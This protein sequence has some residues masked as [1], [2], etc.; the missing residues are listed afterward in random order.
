MPNLAFHLEVLDKVIDKLTTGGDP[1]GS[2]MKN[3]RQFAAL[4]ALGPDL[5][6]YLPISTGLGD[7]LVQ[8]STATPVGQIST[9]PLSQL[10]ELF[11]N[12]V[13]AIYTL[14]FRQVV[15][16]NWVTINQLRDFFSKL[17]AIVASQNQLAIPGI[18]GEAKDVLNKSKA[19]KK[20]L[21]S[22][23]TNVASIVGQII[24]LPPWMQQF[25][26]VP[27]P[28]SEPRANRASE[29]LRWHRTGAFARN[30][31]HG[32]ANDRQRAFAL[33]WLCH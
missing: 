10:Q 31:L 12:P 2:L 5:L 28:P 6:R 4:G 3:N 22:A 18:I 15:I 21:P 24:A 17:D 26:A 30:L 16:P 14:L 11:L 33:G 25:S 13:G 23:L 1:R 9:L 8:L 19:L 29:F 7:A 20:T 32:A 27:V